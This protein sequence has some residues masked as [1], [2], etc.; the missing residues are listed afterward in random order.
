MQG[1]ICIVKHHKCKLYTPVFILL[2]LATVNVIPG[3]TDLG[4][5]HWTNPITLTAVA[6]TFNILQSTQKVWVWSGEAGWAWTVSHRSQES[7]SYS[8]WMVS[9]RTCLQSCERMLGEIWEAAPWNGEQVLWAVPFRHHGWIQLIAVSE[10]SSLHFMGA[11]QYG[12]YQYS[13]FKV[14]M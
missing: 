11:L 7:L 5:V 10:I 9:P 14:A 4:N 2:E 3:F 12:V 6:V 8:W 13:S 1:A